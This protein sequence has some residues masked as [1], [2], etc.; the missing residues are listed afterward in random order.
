VFILE[1][2]E[3]K[4]NNKYDI[5]FITIDKNTNE[6]IYYHTLKILINKNNRL[7]YITKT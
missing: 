6:Y 4:Y 2:L 7:L 3:L 5:Y 1:N